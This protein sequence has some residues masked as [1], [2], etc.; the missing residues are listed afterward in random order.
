MSLSYVVSVHCDRCSVWVGQACG[1]K[2]G[3]LGRDALK[4]AKALGWSRDNKST[5]LDLCPKCLREFR[6]NPDIK[7]ATS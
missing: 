6:N 4:E 5:M 2:P 3:G 7:G 1:P